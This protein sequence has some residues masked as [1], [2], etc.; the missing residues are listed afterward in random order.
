MTRYIVTPMKTLLR[1][2]RNIN[3]HR[4]A[5]E[6]DFL[7]FHGG[8]RE[9][10]RI[11]T[12]FAKLFKVVRV[13]NTAFFSGN[14]KWAYH[15]VKDALHLFRKVEDEKAV[16]IACNNL[17]NTLFAMY[18]DAYDESGFD[19]N[20][21]EEG[22][23][24]SVALKHYEE[25]IEIGQRQF[26]E[27]PESELKANFAYQL[28]DRLFNRGL[29]LLLI[30]GD[31]SA[32]VDTRQQ[33]FRDISRARDL[34]YDVKDYMLEHKLLLKNSVPYYDRLIRRINGLT[35]FY[36]DVQL[37][38]VWDVRELIEDADK[39]LHASWREPGAPLFDEVTRFGRLQQLEGCA[40]ELWTHMDQ[41]AEAARLAMRMFS[42]DAYI[43]ETSFT[44]A[45]DALLRI[46]RESN[47]EDDDM[48]FSR[49][50]VSCVR[51][52]LRRMAK[53]CK[54]VTLDTG[55]CLVFTAE[56]SERW[57]GDPLLDKINANCLDLYDRCCT[58]NDY[59][60]VVA[61]TTQD[62]LTLDLKPKDGNEGRQRTLLDIAT[63]STS[64]RA[65]P[66]FPLAIQMVV[67]SQASLEND[68]FIVLMLDG[69][70]WDSE[71]CSSLRLQIDRLNRERG[72]K[73]HLL[74][75]GM[76]MDM[77]SDD[78][79]RQCQELGTVSKLSMYADATL[80]NVDG[81]FRDF[82]TAIA[83]RNVNSGFLR[84]IT[85]ERF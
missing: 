28:A 81:I 65:N 11:Y 68:S 73:I 63:S 46:L 13:S 3:N 57:E 55:K 15:F 31:E 45:G 48:E 1:A 79:R 62:S 35:D 14:L 78:A 76:E 70:A 39:F 52:D 30:S 49:K 85:M 61:Y 16:G 19:I 7:P 25:A 64:E 54:N 18:Y 42:E 36:D 56:L 69:Y 82:A 72:T 58:A 8:S 26:D 38:E 34:D 53:F 77:E 50:T 9:T 33:A 4:D 84:G 12:T 80:E 27:T 22:G 75:V 71:A 23:L 24:V 21:S 66:T 5:D 20:P 6:N 74:I 40:I 83:G 41:L 17:G 67:D 10:A 44:R 60:G 59:M 29:F 2:V 43:L 51:E 32:P 47:D 37:Q